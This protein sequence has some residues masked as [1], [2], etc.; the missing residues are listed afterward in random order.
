[1]RRAHSRLLIANDW[2]LQLHIDDDQVDALFGRGWRSRLDRHAGHIGG[3]LHEFGIHPGIGEIF[4]G[5]SI[6]F[7]RGINGDDNHFKVLVEVADEV[8]SSAGANAY[9]RRLGHCSG[10]AAFAGDSGLGLGWLLRW[11]RRLL[12]GAQAVRPQR[13][14]ARL[15]LGPLLDRA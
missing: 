7:A 5:D 10:D 9:P 11:R 3:R 6:P 8:V 4:V 13:R 14:S 15:R 2:R 1:M 12:H